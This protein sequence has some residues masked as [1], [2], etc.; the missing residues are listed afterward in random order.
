MTNKVNKSYNVY[1]CST[2]TVLWVHSCVA[3]LATHLKKCICS[4]PL[5]H[6]CLTASEEVIGRAVVNAIKKE[7]LAMIT[8]AYMRNYHLG[9]FTKECKIS[10]I[11][12]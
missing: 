12:A 2:G 11:S 3:V 4:G 8:K 10:L 7:M 9:L 5:F 1:T 6:R